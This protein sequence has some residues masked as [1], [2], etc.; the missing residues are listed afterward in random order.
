[1]ELNVEG[2]Y[3]Q[4]FNESILLI[5]NFLSSHLN[6]QYVCME[7]FFSVIQIKLMLSNFYHF[8]HYIKIKYII[9]I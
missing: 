1:M 2:L 9:M 8:Y 7:I 5:N 4:Y 3:I 6:T